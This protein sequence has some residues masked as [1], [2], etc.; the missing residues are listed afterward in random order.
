MNEIGDSS[1]LNRIPDLI[2]DN[3]VPLNDDN[4]DWDWDNNDDE[5][6]FRC[7]CLFCS[8]Y[9]DLDN[10]LLHMSN[11]HN[12]G[13]KEL[14]QLSCGNQYIYFKIINWCRKTLP[15]LQQLLDID[16]DWL[17]SNSSDSFLL[18]TLVNDGLLMV[19]A[20]WNDSTTGMATIPT[21]V[22]ELDDSVKQELQA[23]QEEEQKPTK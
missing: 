5:M 2:T 13:L 8:E 17:F 10:I 4:D 9:N 22:D 18:P 14:Y 3:V 11:T 16:K 20:D 21:F 6:S 12:C 19:D 1:Q 7:K 23:I 15:S